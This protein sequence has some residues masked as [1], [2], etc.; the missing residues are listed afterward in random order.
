VSTAIGSLF[1][2]LRL[3]SQNYQQKIEEA[4]RLTQQAGQQMQA[5]V[6]IKPQID[7]R[8]LQTLSDVARSTQKSV[9]SVLSDKP[10]RLKADV[11]EVE[12]LKNSIDEIPKSVA[13]ARQSLEQTFKFRAQS[14]KVGKQIESNLQLD[15]KVNHKPLTELNEH[16]SLKQ[17]HFDQVQG[18]FNRNPLTPKVDISQIKSSRI[19]AQ[20][21]NS[22]LAKI[23]ASLNQVLK[24]NIDT[25]ELT[26]IENRVEKIKSQQI[27]IKTSFE[28]PKEQERKPKEQVIKVRQESSILGG[29]KTGFLEG[30]GQSFALRLGGGLVQGVE[31][32]LN[33]NL[34]NIGDRFGVRY[35][36]IARN[37]SENF[38]QSIGL[39]DGS[40]ALTKEFNA[41]LLK[42]E[43]LS[44]KSATAIGTTLKQA[45]TG[46]FAEAKREA[47]ALAKDIAAIGIDSGFS[48]VRIR[49]REVAKGAA[50]E[51]M[52]RQGSVEVDR[53]EAIEKAKSIT[54]AT[55]GLNFSPGGKENTDFIRDLLKPVL[56]GSYIVGVN[57]P[58]TNDPEGFATQFNDFT[59]KL[60]AGLGKDIGD[61][62]VKNLGKLAEMAIV[63][64][65]NPDAISMAATAYAYKQAYP[66][67]GINLVGT[68]GGGH[69]AADAVHLLEQLGIDSKGLGITTPFAGL[70]NV[71]NPKKFRAQIGTADPLYQ[72]MFGM[73]VFKPGDVQDVYPGVGLG[74][75]LPKFLAEE[76]VQKD[77]Q[78]FLGDRINPISPDVTGR[79][80]YVNMLGFHTKKASDS[81]NIRGAIAQSQGMQGESWFYKPDESFKRLDDLRGYIT[82]VQEV[83]KKTKGTVKSE[84]ES[85]I[86]FLEEFH[87][88]LEK[89]FATGRE[90]IPDLS[91]A[92]QYYPEA[93]APNVER[94]LYT[95]RSMN[96][97][98]QDYRYRGKTESEIGNFRRSVSA[99]RGESVNGYSY[100]QKDAGTK[101][102]IQGL[103]Q[104]LNTLSGN[105]S[106]SQSGIVRS[107]QQFIASLSGLI[108]RYH[109]IGLDPNSWEIDSIEAQLNDL[110]AALKQ[111]FAPKLE[112]DQI[113]IQKAKIEKT[114]TELATKTQS[115]FRRVANATSSAANA[116]GLALLNNK[117]ANI[118]AF[119]DEQGNTPQ[120]A[121]FSDLS[122]KG[123]GA[124]GRQDMES[125]LAFFQN[126]I[127]KGYGA[128]KGVEDF[129][130]NALPFGKT[131]KTGLQQIALPAVA[132][133]MATHALPGGGAIASGATDAMSQAL[134]LP[135]ESMGEAITLAVNNSMGEAIAQ[136]PFIG[137]KLAPALQTGITNL[138][139]GAV[140]N[141]ASGAASVSTPV[142]GGQ[143][144]L[145]PA[146]MAGSAIV[147]DQ[148]QAISAA[149]QR[150]GVLKAGIDQAQTFLSA[151]PDKA[152]LHIQGSEGIDRDINL[153]K[154][155]IDQGIAA[156][157]PLQRTGSIEGNQLAQLKGQI[158]QQEKKLNQLVSGLKQ[159]VRSPQEMMRSSVQGDIIDAEIIDVTPI[160]SASP[161]AL[162][163]AKDSVKQ[164]EKNAIAQIKK[165]REVFATQTKL[166]TSGSSESSEVG[167]ELQNS[168]S[169]ARQEIDQVMS[170]IGKNASKPLREAA[171][172]ARAQIT[173]TETAVSKPSQLEG[174][175]IGA[176]VASGLNEGLN[177]GISSVRAAAARL[178]QAAIGGAEDKLEI[179]SPSRVFIKIGQFAVQGLEQGLNAIGQIGVG[180]NLQPII[181][182]VKNALSGLAPEASKAVGLMGKAFSMIPAPIRGVI[183]AFFGF[184]ALSFVVPFF[185]EFTQNAAKTAMEIEALERSLAFTEG[186]IDQGIAKLKAINTEAN[187][188]GVNAQKAAEGYTKIAS[189][190]KDTPLEGLGAEQF[191]KG[192]QTAAIASNSNGQRQELVNLAGAQMIQKGVLSQEE[193]RQQMA[194]NLQGVNV[195]AVLARSMN[196]D[197]PKL[198]KMIESGIVTSDV[199]PGFGQ[200][201]QAELAIP[202]EEASKSAQAS[203]NRLE[204]SITQIQATAGKGILPVQALGAESIAKLLSTINTNAD[205]LLASI[206][207]LSIMF[208]FTLLRSLYA[209]ISQFVMLPK[210]SALSASSF[211]AMGSSIAGAAGSIGLFAARFGILTIAIMAATKAW[212]V[213]QD[214][215]GQLRTTAD[216]SKKALEDLQ[217]TLRPEQSQQVDINKD[218]FSPDL[219]KRIAARDA[220]SKN[221]NIFQKAL[222]TLNNSVDLTNIPMQFDRFMGRKT[223]KDKD[224]AISDMQGSSVT[225]IA[226]SKGLRQN[227]SEVARIQQANKQIEDLQLQ[228]R[229]LR[230]TN[231]D[232]IQGLN[233]LKRA[234]EQI[235]KQSEPLFEIKAKNQKTISLYVEGL[236]SQIE[237]LD[238]DPK[239]TKEVERLKKLLIEAEQEQ[240]DFNQSIGSSASQLERFA[241]SWE[242]VTAKMRD[243]SAELKNQETI[244]TTSINN[245]QAAGQITPGQAQFSKSLASQERMRLDATQTK[246]KIAELRSQLD[247]QN[248]GGILAQ[249]KL[250]NAGQQEL[251]SAAG[252][253]S[254]GSKE[255]KVF[256]SVAQL[257][258]LEQQA[259]QMDAELSGS[260]AQVSEE[261]YSSNKSIID[262]YRGIARQIEDINAS[263]KAQSLEIKSLNLRSRIDEALTG[264][265][266][267]FVSD[268]SDAIV[269]MLDAV[270]QKGKNTLSALSAQTQALRRNEDAALQAADLNRGL[271]NGSVGTASGGAIAS[272]LY[273]APTSRNGGSAEYH[274]DTKFHKN[275]S[276]AARVSMMDAIANAYAAEGRKIEFSNNAVSGETYNPS[277][278]KRG[279]LLKRAQS[280]HSHSQ[281]AEWDSVDYYIPKKND[282]RSGKSA[283]N[284]QIMLP[285]IPGG[286]VEYGSGGSYGNHA[287]LYDAKGNLVAKTGHGDDGRSLPQNRS[288][289][290]MQ[291]TQ[292]NPRSASIGSV[293]GFDGNRID[294]SVAILMK[295]GLSA[296]GASMLTGS[297]MQ[298]SGL[299]TDAD[300]GS[301]HGI[302]QWDKAH[303]G[304]NLPS[305]FEDQ[306][307][308]AVKEGL[309]DTPSAIAT[310]RDP[311]AN[312]DQV[313]QAIRNLTRYGAGEE[314]SRFKY[315]AEI[316]SRM[317]KGGVPN[318]ASGNSQSIDFSG[319]L[320]VLGQSGQ[321]ESQSNMDFANAQNRQID[322]STARQMAEARLNLS[323]SIQENS[324]EAR[325]MSESVQDQMRSIG[326][327]TPEKASRF[328]AIDITR[329]AR[330]QG[331]Q[332]KTKL[333]EL[334][335]ALQ[336]IDVQEKTVKDA[337][338][339]GQVTKDRANPVL[340][341]IKNARTETKK[342][343]QTYK[344]TEKLIASA[345]KAQ[346]DD[347]AVK[348]ALAIAQREN[349]F[350]S[351]LT[352]ID[353]ERFSLEADRV[354]RQGDSRGF[355]KFQKSSQEADLRNSMASEIQ[356]VQE[357]ARSSGLAQ[358]KVDLLMVGLK[359]LNQLK[360]DK[361]ENEA[362]QL[363]R[364]LDIA[365]REE[366]FGSINKVGDAEIEGFR[367]LGMDRFAKDIER[368]KA[369]AQERFGYATEMQRINDAIENRGITKEAGAIASQNV[370]RSF[371][372]RIDNIKRQY[373]VLNEVIAQSKG[374]FQDF[375]TGLINGSE[376]F[377]S[378][379]GK[380]VTTIANNLASMASQFLT[381]EIMGIFTGKNRNANEKDAK[382]LYGDIS[383][384]V[385]YDR[386]GKELAIAADDAGTR[387]VGLSEKAGQIIIDS[388]TQFASAIANSTIGMDQGNLADVI[389]RKFGTQSLDSL[390]GINSGSFLDA[391][392]YGLGNAQISEFKGNVSSNDAMRYT[393]ILSSTAIAN[394]GK[395]SEDLFLNAEKASFTIAN[396]V[397]LASEFLTD[398]GTKT[399]D[400]LLGGLSQGLPGIIQGIVGLFGGGGKKG[401]FGGLLSSILP[402]VGG[403]FGGGAAAI[404][405]IV[406]PIL[407]LVPNFKEGG[408]VDGDLFKGG[409]NPIAQA[410]RREGQG[411]IVGVMNKGEY[412]LTPPETQMFFAMGFD[413]IVKGKVPNYRSGGSV[414]TGAASRF[415][416]GNDISITV[417]VTVSDGSNVDPQQLGESIRGAVQNEI[418][419][420]QRPGG[421]LY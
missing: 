397:Q 388:A 253:A 82:A 207:A 161:L 405:D 84:A 40:Q 131:A 306:V 398:S 314:K 195:S 417:P 117:I 37:I 238:K 115:V 175:Q 193:I 146:R 233:Q 351:R 200:Q 232:D 52:S 6:N 28:E 29:L 274:I 214:Q 185:A 38:V 54:I 402:I 31:K 127:G 199:L 362:R 116:G 346:L 296:L 345:Q 124:I 103:S 143:A 293:S 329:S 30:I 281:Y 55:G 191:Y 247:A 299:R 248:A 152:R 307:R 87:T 138:I 228:Q 337:I 231:P 173:R 42:W 226:E 139:E 373:S 112:I 35:S 378:A 188:L 179:K 114:T 78:S 160:K 183:S 159:M 140:Q 319:A 151:R 83:S 45:I 339:S 322:A 99:M 245:A 86:Q 155:Q 235:R 104:S 171:K 96:A 391:D 210:L 24:L 384:A 310:L 15:P 386:Q 385:T 216:T 80:G 256:E 66:E 203:F 372:K 22:D 325:A 305:G 316:F 20:G 254:E 48:P 285:T 220:E 125:V 217:K 360:L 59:R 61:L 190:A 130:L 370:D 163:A 338:T 320:G 95:N 136:I 363:N 135:L 331:E 67:K 313:E 60:F 289:G 347:N 292:N 353:T 46:N 419:R 356:S 267:T 265:R 91:K 242:T 110:E 421:Q 9:Q 145:A 298:E 75:L 156:L 357:F 273:T 418:A 344:D 264:V 43:A 36:T 381:E 128:L 10:L 304:R 334:Q 219:N 81:G 141:L 243:A 279:D 224:R 246:Q 352:R 122:T 108:D 98:L 412:I 300:N 297:F 118:K 2:E 18:H 133:N 303:R 26:A 282:N 142:L 268:F 63:K 374:A 162:P 44:E 8:S 420:Q 358:D 309:Q 94:P 225:A 41:V 187:L 366:V 271:P 34:K 413:K 229:A 154:G 198:N 227:R 1:L 177:Q 369:L 153:L 69:V 348:E 164:A 218:K 349:E 123:Y 328:K 295:E 121:R 202:A 73:G 249:Y 390:G 174:S 260:I 277:D 276:D 377:G 189:A 335:A 76:S 399:S 371:G 234:E 23:R 49:K 85:Y 221:G 106:E 7:T 266:K 367:I 280:A 406:S 240:K 404:P 147:G 318:G 376:S 178:A 62:D 411:A 416:T 74:H 290:Q 184:Q 286:R 365:D 170:A 33:V 395:D 315:G 272:G 176:N 100:F 382:D 19:E 58:A 148:S 107:Q 150:M 102:H 389:D 252:R 27:K 257:K 396:G 204:N 14:L 93:I 169:L 119:Q 326:F 126:T 88:E 278:P 101:D 261:L 71:T 223:E 383:P 291:A 25:S 32:N 302:M 39:S 167:R 47:I 50:K 17:K 250:S 323:R 53:N 284:A 393:K 11:T 105:A 181:Q 409:N 343:I 5:S 244:A 206:S 269:N 312:R 165:L 340:A 208:G 213:F 57:N 172:Q 134:Q 209:V 375:F 262:Y 263:V 132:F 403:L 157:T 222:N 180:E 387:F 394:I 90:Y 410:V 211:R 301:H 414:G 196:V 259:N 16:L 287:L 364:A 186:G 308:F 270:N 215:S 144:L 89:H 137:S 97:A 77:I 354:G 401:G 194:E 321:I 192:L 201:L 327:D 182:E 120:V 109:E 111:P 380:L 361:I 239:Y 230:A 92:K 251:T 288:F 336:E 236:K 129:T 311:K 342:L 317:Q 255:K 72:R 70:A 56:P 21:L 258:E 283:E 212:A 408:F 359:A 4:R 205:T 275:L 166:A 333:E 400:N 51:V 392:S 3:D 13:I 12:Q 113:A 407:N 355:I 294:R 64:G 197:V 324:K 149:R 241:K 350:I 68:S 158:V 332:I 379:F 415:A 79:K 341:S 368:E 168:I 330:D 237:E 65:I